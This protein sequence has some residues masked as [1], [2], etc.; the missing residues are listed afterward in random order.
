MITTESDEEDFLARSYRN[1]G[2]RGTNYGGLHHDFGNSSRITELGALLGL[3]QLRKLP[4]MLR[5]RARV[6]AAIIAP[7]K[8]AGLSYCSTDHMDVASYYKLIV[9]LPERRTLEKVK[10][11]LAGEGVVIGGGVYELPCHRQPVFTDICAG[12]SYPGADRWCPN[13]LCPPLTS[14]MTEDEGRFVGEML[15]KYLC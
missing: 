11:E 9:L 4:E 7:L 14:G 3:I 15:V 13:H 8:R 6:A 2:K 5:Q 12:G 1:Q 10:K